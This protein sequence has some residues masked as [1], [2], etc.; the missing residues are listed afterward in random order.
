[1]AAL[2]KKMNI[3]LRDLLEAGV[4]FGHQTRRWNPKMKPYIYGAKNGIHIMDLQS[5][6]RGLVEACKFISGLLVR[7]TLCGHKACFSRSLG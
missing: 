6:A 1:M 3:S 4:H 7:R 2:E 5:T